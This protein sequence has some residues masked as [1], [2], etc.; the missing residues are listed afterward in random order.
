MSSVNKFLVLTYIFLLLSSLMVFSV[1]F[2]NV[3]AVSK[4]SVPQFTVKFIDKSYDVPPTQ[5]TDPYTGKTTTQPGYHV[6]DGLLEVTIKNQ[7]FTPSPTSNNHI[8]YLVEVKGRFG[9]DNDWDNFLRG[10]SDTGGYTKQSDS[11]YTVVTGNGRYDSGVQLDFRVKAIVGHLQMIPPMWQMEVESE[12]SWSKI[13]TTTITYESSPTKP[14]QTANSPGA[15]TSDPNNPTQQNPLALILMVILIAAC[16]IAFLIAVI[17][18]QHKQIKNNFDTPSS[19]LLAF[20][21]FRW[22]WAV[23]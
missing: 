16:I 8:H 1:N 20:R 23:S 17:A 12:S 4:P 2:A 9:G 14:S 5:T 11:G 7:P 6:N 15:S 21:C 22:V 3:Y 13:Q 10:L 18:R 19:Q